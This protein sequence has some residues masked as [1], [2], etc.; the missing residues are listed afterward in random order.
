[1]N[2]IDVIGSLHQ[3]GHLSIFPMSSVP[4]NSDATPLSTY[5]Q[6][7]L[8]DEDDQPLAAP[9]LL[10]VIGLLGVSHG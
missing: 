7:L 5:A 3:M 6:M 1:M 10:C 9:T 4:I 8:V 2:A